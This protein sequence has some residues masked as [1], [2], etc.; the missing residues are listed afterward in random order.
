MAIGLFGLA[1]AHP[2]IAQDSE[3]PAAEGGAIIVTGSRIQGVAPVGAT[4]TTL[5]RAEIEQAGT[6]TVDR[7]IKELPQVFDLGISENSRAQAGGNGNATWG[8][9]INLR[10][11][12]PFSTLII[13]DGHRMVS[14]GRAIDPSV[15]P[16]LG[17]ERV[18]VIAD[19]AS[20][21]YGSDAIAGVVN[22]IPRRNLDGGEAFARYGTAE[23]GAYWE[24]NAGLA[25]GKVW[26]RGQVMIAYEH[27]KRSNLS[28]EDR[29]F[30]VSDQTP[31]GGKDYRTRQCAPGT[32]IAGGVSYAMPA[33]LT[34]ANAASLVP[35]TR[36]L[37]ESLI[38]GDLSPESE[39]DSVNGTA[40][41]QVLDNVE[42][43]FD[44]FYSHREF[45]RIPGALTFDL[46][47]P[48]TNAFYVAPPGFAGN[49]YTI[50]YSF[51]NDIAPDVYSGETT[52]WQVT[53][54]IKIKLPHEWQLQGIVGFGKTDDDA[55]S[56][57]GL[58]RTALTAALASSDPNKAF[59]PYG[60]GRTNPAVLKDI[61]DVP[62]YFP[63][64]AELTTYQANANGPLFSLPGGE[65]KLAVGYERQEFEMQLSRDYVTWN[66][67]NRAVD[68][69]YAELFL[70]L[71][72]PGNATPGFEEL[73][74][75]AAVRHD[76]YS[77]VGGTTNPKFGVN[78]TPVEGVK[79][80]GTYGTSF[81]APSF[82]EIY[83]NSTFLYGQAYTNPSGTPA[84]VLGYTYGSGPNLDLG[85]ET[86]TTWTVGA[87]FEPT[88]DL[89][90][91]L[92][93]F[94]IAYDNQIVG[95]LSNL[96][97]LSLE[98]QYAGT[99][100]I[101]RG[102]AAK[103]RIEQLIAA[104]VVVRPIA[105]V[106]TDATPISDYIFV[107]GRSLNLGRSQMSGIDFNVSYFLNLGTDDSLTFQ[108]NGTYLTEYKVA[109]SSAGKLLDLKNEI[110]QPLTFK[111][112][113]SVSWE[114][115]PVTT[116]LQATHVGGYENTAITPSEKVNSYTPVDLSVTWR[117][118]E[119]FEGD[120]FK[121]LTL[122]GEVRNLF[123]VDP[124][125][126]NLAKSA[127]GG[128]GFDPTAANPIGRLFALSLRKQF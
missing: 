106:Y 57:L 109:V 5:G 2:A 85:P 116:R 80:R 77:D 110:F 53:P 25:L 115:G 66:I 37:C 104:G 91:S 72:G 82:P 84:T 118:G 41:W 101:L 50:A 88:Q 111:A 15:L 1:A 13:T 46:T 32:I 35:G 81:R 47:V 27:A 16:S 94:D 54:G 123:N 44:G 34:P 108:A 12:G 97:V 64:K 28:G 121:G 7:M 38:G 69:V 103:D 124:P 36:N 78:W 92:T 105:G 24:W 9:S 33:E 89:R 117:V 29:D 99:G 79:L 3:G 114:H 65:V 73:V 93:Y 68:S 100:V 52:S 60:L 119:S 14:N 58:D 102:Q 67:Y 122:S 49:S 126:V 76:A 55:A 39:Y 128:G 48:N 62:A 42:L 56:Y 87:D 95:L 71:F 45:S 10:G 40:S 8:N 51:E 86:S 6:I 112:R 4:V 18:E 23:D 83:G 11:L 70:P 17:V 22:L 59:D 125:Y 120:A 43:L 31:F 96:A 61:F 90:V 74:I 63:T 98:D 107:D 113:A 30:Y 21:I 19:G 26:D 75:N 20:A 127:N